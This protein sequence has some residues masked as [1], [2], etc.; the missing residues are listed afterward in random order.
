MVGAV[1]LRK[2]RDDYF[3]I[4]TL[5]IALILALVIGQY[6]PLFDGYEGLY[7]MP[8]PLSSVGPLGPDGGNFLGICITAL[9][10]TFLVHERLGKSPLAGP[11]SRSARTTPRRPRS[12]GTCTW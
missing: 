3:G 5:A 10:V 2:L 1:A 11:S 7:G 12:A 6:T 8:Q 4:T 9:I